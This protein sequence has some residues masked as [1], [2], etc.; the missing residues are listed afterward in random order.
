VR[1][2]TVGT[3]FGQKLARPLLDRYLARTG[4]SSQ[5]TGH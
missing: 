5:Q 4:Y 3:L 2:S 1:A